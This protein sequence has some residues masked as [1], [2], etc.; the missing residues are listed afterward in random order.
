MKNILENYLAI[1]S[2]FI[3]RAPFVGYILE[4][5]TAIDYIE[6]QNELHINK[7]ETITVSILRGN[8][9]H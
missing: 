5:A 6:F 1:L 7:V 9:T 3:A 2:I 4:V 8:T